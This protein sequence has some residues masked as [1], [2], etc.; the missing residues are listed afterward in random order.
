MEH[1]KIVNFQCFYEV[2]TQFKYVAINQNGTLNGF[3]NAPIRDFLTCEW[4]DSVTGDW[5]TMIPFTKWDTSV[6][7]VE[8]LTDMS[9]RMPGIK[10][11]NEAL[12]NATTYKRGR[13][14]AS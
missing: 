1:P 3:Q 6:R 10:K 11:H 13:K 7:K 9:T 5:G 2:P 8:E 12:K 4:Q 14:T